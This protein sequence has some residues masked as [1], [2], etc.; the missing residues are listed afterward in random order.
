[1]SHSGET[2][3]YV[4]IWWPESHSGCPTS[5]YGSD[6][7]VEGRYSFCVAE[8][9]NTETQ[10]QSNQ[11]VRYH[12]ALSSIWGCYLGSDV[13]PRESVEMIVVN[14]TAVST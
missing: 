10:C 12:N 6:V 5:S 2:T 7:A 9:N 11:P 4:N 14:T 1:M 3:Y 13:L 8:E